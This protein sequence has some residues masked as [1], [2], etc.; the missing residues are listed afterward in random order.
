MAVHAAA[1]LPTATWLDERRAAP[2]R[3][4]ATTGARR[5]RRALGDRSADV[6]VLLIVV[7]AALFELIAFARPRPALRHHLGMRG[8]HA[9]IGQ[10]HLISC[11]A[12]PM[13]LDQSEREVL[14]VAFT[15]KMA[16]ALLDRRGERSLGGGGC[17]LAARALFPG[18]SAPA[19]C[20]GNP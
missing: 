11:K 10:E 9:P 3:T 18:P 17:V 7:I 1:V 15:L 20:S 6:A 12:S 5:L 8:H 14:V 16:L 2:R 13:S 4:D 19:S